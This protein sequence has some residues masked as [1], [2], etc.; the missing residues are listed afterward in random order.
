[1]KKIIIAGAVSVTMAAIPVLTSFA[2]TSV[3]VDYIQIELHD[4]CAFSRT[5]SAGVDGDPVSEYSATIL[6]GSYSSGFGGST[7]TVSCNIP[8]TYYVTAEFTDLALQGG[9]ELIPYDI[10]NPDGSNTLWT[11][12]MGDPGEVPHNVV[13]GD[14]ILEADQASGGASA[15]VHYSVG[16]AVGQA[17]G[18]YSGT[19]TYTLVSGV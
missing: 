19:A 14:T 8:D 12:T 4:T 6:P 10:V 15:S 3:V 17:S 2:E 11:T 18:S 9:S 5:S 13:N 16:A 7:L 1:M